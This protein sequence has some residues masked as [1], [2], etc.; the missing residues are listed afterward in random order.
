MVGIRA[1]L[2][3]CGPAGCG[4]TSGSAISSALMPEAADWPTMPWCSTMRRSRNGRK[5]SVPAISTISNAWM[6]ISPCDTRHTASA[7]A[8]AAPIATP[9]SVMPRVMTPVESTRRVLSHNS[10]ARSARR[11]PKARLWPKAFSVGSPWTP[12]RNS[13]PKDFS[14]CWR[15]W[16]VRRSTCTKTIGAINVTSAKT[17]ITAATGTSQN[18]IKAK[19]ASGVSTAIDN[20][21]TYWPKKVCNCSTPS[22]I[23]SMTPPVR[24]PANQAGPSSATLS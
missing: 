13:E 3:G 18:A 12:S 11:R 14:A 9:Q 20:C 1:I 15:P 2:P 23:D 21:G 7:S 10:R 19:I 6:F 8:A 16:L 24:S 17:S 22:T 5:I 4:G